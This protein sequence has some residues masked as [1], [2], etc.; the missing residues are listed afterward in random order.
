MT[1]SL[2]HRILIGLLA[3]LAAT[4]TVGSATAAFGAEVPSVRVRFAD[5]DLD[6][7][8]G[9]L[10]LYRRLDAAAHE[11]CHT[12]EDR[13]GALVPWRR[14]V[15]SALDRAVADVGSPRL[16]RYHFDRTGTS[17]VAAAG[18]PAHDLEPAA[19]LH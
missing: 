16:S 8:Q 15:S 3:A 12:Y 14:C 1:T 7:P 10:A 18:Q 6:T 5:L 4:V 2:I 11:V 19:V 17:G 13:L 9:T